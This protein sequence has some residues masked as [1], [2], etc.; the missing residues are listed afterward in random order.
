MSIRIVYLIGAGATQAEIDHRGGEKINL[1]MQDNPELGV[2]GLATRIIKRAK[3]YNRLNRTPASGS[4]TDVEKL[5]SLLDNTGLVAHRTA[6]SELRQLYREEILKALRKTKVIQEP[7]LAIYLLRMHKSTTFNEKKERLV[8]IIDLNHD[9]L[10]QVASQKVHGGI[11]V[12]FAFRQRDFRFQEHAPRI[13]KPHGSFNWYNTRPITVSAV[14][15]KRSRDMLWIP[16]T[17]LKESKDYPYNKLTGVAHEMLATNCDVLRIVGCRLSQ[18]DWNIVSLLFNAQY[19]QSLKGKG[20]FRVELIMPHKDGEDIK[21]EYSYLQ[22]LV[23]IGYLQDGDFSPYLQGR[24]VFAGRRRTRRLVTRS[25]QG[26]ET[27]SELQ[28]PFKY[29]LKTK[30]R[31]HISRNELR[32]D[33]ELPAWLS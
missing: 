15:T 11:N 5:I 14:E 16:P 6:A 9:W 19:H 30:I 8:G 26:S 17:I 10:L 7:E 1:L 29:W 12:C 3:K 27:G 33:E 4:T 23:S 21:K 24:Q 28:N 13:V 22:G 2:L 25:L 31:Y 18:N 32:F 20:C